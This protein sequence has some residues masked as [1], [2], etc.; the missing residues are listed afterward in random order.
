MVTE[1]YFARH[2]FGARESVEDGDRDNVFWLPGIEN[3]AG[4]GRQKSKST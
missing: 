3:P 4:G 1:G 2:L